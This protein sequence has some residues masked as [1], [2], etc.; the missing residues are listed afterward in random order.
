VQLTEKNYYSQEANN[1]FF[2]YSLYKD[3]CKCEAAAMAKLGGWQPPKSTALLVGSYTHTAFEGAAALEKFKAENPEI[4][5]KNGELKAEYRQA[6]TMIETVQNDR[7]MMISLE[8]Q[9][10]VIV[11][12]ELGGV[13]WKCKLDVLNVEKGFFSDLKTCANLSDKVWDKK[14]RVWRHFVEAYGYIGQMALYQEIAG[15]TYGPLDPFMAIV[16]KETPPDKKV[17]CFSP[18][19]LEEELEKIKVNLPRIIEVKT[20]KVKPEPCGKCAYC[21]ETQKLSRVYDFD[22]ICEM[23]L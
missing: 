20:G 22:E 19:R 5:L 7:L 23:Y 8:G 18:E 10:E 2:S 1:E 11:T 12:G 9:K 13:K 4:F 6:N 14:E 15:Q 16:T 3:F 17:I 21:R